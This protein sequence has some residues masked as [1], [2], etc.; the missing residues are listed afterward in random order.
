[1]A[2]LYWR[3]GS[4]E[5]YMLLPGRLDQNWRK[6]VLDAAIGDLGESMRE[7]FETRRAVEA[8]REE[9]LACPV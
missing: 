4:V 3:G 9:A 2:G 8:A 6:S 5:D 7:Y 1:M